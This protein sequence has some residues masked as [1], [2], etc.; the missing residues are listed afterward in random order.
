VIKLVLLD[1]IDLSV[2]NN[3]PILEKVLLMLVVNDL[4]LV[5]DNLELMV[6]DLVLMVD[7]LVL[8]VD[9]LVLMVDDL[10][11][12]VD[13]LVLM[14]D[15]LVLMVSDLV[16]MVSDLVLVVGDLVLVVGDLVL[17]VSDV[18]LVVGDLGWW[19][20]R[21]PG[22]S[23]SMIPDLHTLDRVPRKVR[24][25]LRR[26]HIQRLRQPHENGQTR[27]LQPQLEIADVVP[28]EIGRLRKR[29]LREPAP[30]G[31]REAGDPEAALPASTRRS[32]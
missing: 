4:E 25:Q 17:V 31:A 1:D 6:G 10:V 26:G 8:M 28:G 13:D 16:L 15:D 7:D 32:P 9:D 14:V 29:L 18:V 30:S 24:Q 20:A 23:A 27:H 12:M 5:V 21:V 2:E 19:E 11:L 22:R 3:F